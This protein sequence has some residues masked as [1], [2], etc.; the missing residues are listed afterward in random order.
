MKVLKE[1][2]N[3]FKAS[4]LGDQ[5]LQQTRKALKA[6]KA[7]ERRVAEA[8]NHVFLSDRQNDDGEVYPVICIN[9]TVVYKICTNPRSEKGEISLDNVG[10]VLTRQRIQ[11]AENTLNYR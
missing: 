7:F 11:Y 9:G 4:I 5:S 3:W 2:Q 8:T 6:Q 1:I 10:E